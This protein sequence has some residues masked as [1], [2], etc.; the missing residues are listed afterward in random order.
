MRTGRR[1]RIVAVRIGRL[2]DVILVTPA[3]RLLR[4]RF[5]SARI[6]F[7]TSRYAESLVR[8]LT[9][10]DDVVAVDF[11][12]R[13]PRALQAFA[14]AVRLR[15]R[16]PRFA[17][18]FGRNRWDHWVARIAAPPWRGYAPE[19]I[20]TRYRCPNEAVLDP[21]VRGVAA[22][23]LPR[24]ERRY[25]RACGHTAALALDRAREIC[26]E[27]GR[28]LPLE[29]A[30]DAEDR[31]RAAEALE[32]LGIAP[33]ERVVG[34][35]P[36]CSA[37]RGPGYE[38]FAKRV[39]PAARWAEL[40]R[41]LAG[42][43]GSRVALTGGSDPERALAEAIARD[44]ACGAVCVPKLPIRAFA[45]L[46]ERYAAFVTLDSGPLHIACATGVPLVGLYGPSEPGRYGPWVADPRRARVLRL[47]VPCSPCQGYFK[48]CPENQ[49]MRALRVEDVEEAVLGVLDAAAASVPLRAG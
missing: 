18:A 34:L 23:R 7:V 20:P 36:G 6:T 49:C 2:G 44:A 39:W 38:E 5:P 3:L 35:H 12:D 48:A 19:V 9:S 37:L 21:W 15:M 24:F 11:L 47:G 25:K 31:A 1:E 13:R 27:P 33:G 28:F 43:H 14:A 8:G 30:R 46:L 29:V 26:G 40:A 41:S 4:E 32:G 16:R 42:R 22:E 17:V 10:V 45:A